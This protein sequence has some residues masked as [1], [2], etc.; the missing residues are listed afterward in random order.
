MLWEVSADGTNLHPVLPSWNFAGGSCGGH[1]TPDGKYLLF[2]SF[3]DG[4]DEIWAI[5]ERKEFFRTGK[6]EPIQL[7]R[8]PS[9]FGRPTPS[10]D[11]KRIFADGWKD[12]PDTLARYDSRIGQF[13]PYLPGVLGDGL[14]FTH[15]GKWVVYTAVPESTLWR[16]RVD[17]SERLQLTFP[18][19]QVALPRWSPDGKQIA[20][21][22]RLPGKLWSIY[23]VSP[24]GGVAER[25]SLTERAEADPTWSP[26]G[27][28]LAFSQILGFSDDTSAIYVLDLRSRQVSKVPA[29]D[30]RYSPRW[31]PDG[32]YLAV[33]PADSQ[34]LLL[35]E[36]TTEKWSEL[37]Q[38]AVIGYPSW[39][40][41]GK[42]VYFNTKVGEP[43]ILRVRISDRNVERVA[44]LK[45]VSRVYGLGAWL[46]LGPDDSPLILRG[47]SSDEIYALDWEAP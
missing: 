31:S 8:G 18:P 3:K 19:M 40:R 16:S 6:S 27:R 38:A 25:M 20:F 37:A 41:D 14:D 23:L 7:T 9:H 33:M 34:K 43:A 2:D 15:D 1:W 28:K 35:F 5:R 44:D 45:G 21:A 47:T 30:G 42:Y 36:F 39:S 32:R 10:K 17:G 26:D 12:E 22:G 24:E 11:G 13:V 46:G 29:S 4:F